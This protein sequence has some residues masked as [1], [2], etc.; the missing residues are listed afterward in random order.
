MQGNL[1]L[2]CI[3]RYASNGTLLIQGDDFSVSDAMKHGR[4][5]FLACFCFPC[6]KAL[7]YEVNQCRKER[8]SAN[9]AAY[10]RKKGMPLSATRTEKSSMPGTG[11]ISQGRPS[12]RMSLI[13]S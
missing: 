7:L 4:Y 1:L 3:K 12:L 9:F 10:L 6:P 8:F 2:L 5:S 13:P 11:E